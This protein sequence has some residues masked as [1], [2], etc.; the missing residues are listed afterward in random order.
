MIGKQDGTDSTEPK[1]DATTNRRT[2]MGALGALTSSVIGTS[3]LS[4][5]AVAQKTQRKGANQSPRITAHR[6]YADIYPEN[7]VAAVAGS[8]RFKAD[9]IEVDIQPSKDGE[10]VVFHDDYLDDLTDKEGPVAEMPA[11]TVLEAEVLESGE[12][13]PT[14]EEVLDAARPSITLNIEFK[15]AGEYSWKEV[16]ERTLEIAS[17]YPGEWYVSSFETAALEAVRDTNSA[18]PVA[19]LFGSNTERNLQTARELDAEAINPSLNVL[20]ADLVEAA[21]EEGREVNVYTIDS[22][23]EARQARE[24]NV[25][26]IIADYPTVLDFQG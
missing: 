26:G 12:T 11:E 10:I 25:D 18:V 20:D 16:A 15:A 6:G 1:V 7:T 13:I 24:L 19:K 2:F 5:T 14:L 4:N 17:D 23:Q 3:V 9:R 21:H 22:W 8:S